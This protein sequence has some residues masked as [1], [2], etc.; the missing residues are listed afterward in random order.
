MLSIW[1]GSLA[2][3]G[4][5]MVDYLP[6]KG[7]P[8]SRERVA[9]SCGAWSTGHLPESTHHSAS[10]IHGALS[11]P[12]WTS[13]RSRKWIQV[14]ATD[15][16]YIAARERLHSYLADCLWDLFSRMY[17]VGN[18]G[19]ALNTGILPGGLG[20]GSCWWRKPTDLPLR[21]GVSVVF[22]V[23]ATPH[24]LRDLG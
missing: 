22:S 14:W 23:V 21:S 17:S 8:I 19:A 10:W 20:D 11:L 2:A 15:I 6:E 24:S 1:R 12:G 13:R 4:R 16:T 5:R 7:I 9:N 3:A 18:S